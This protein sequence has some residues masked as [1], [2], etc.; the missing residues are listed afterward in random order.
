MLNGSSFSV[1]TEFAARAHADKRATFI[2]QETGGGYGGNSSGLFAITQ[3][4]NSKIDLGIGLFG[5]HMA[6]LPKDLTPEQGI[7]PD[8]LIE[9]TVEDVLNGRD[10]AMAYTLNLIRHQQTKAALS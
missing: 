10:P 3:L 8:Y 9:P 7:V 2:G 1:T 5:F 6:D 4:P